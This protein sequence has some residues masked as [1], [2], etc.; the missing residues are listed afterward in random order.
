MWPLWDEEVAVRWGSSGKKD[1]PLV[2]LKSV[3]K[4]HNYFL[5]GPY[6]IPNAL[7]SLCD[8]FVTISRDKVPL[9]GQ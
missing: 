3:V 9:P 1:C 4:K 8:F 7:K 5:S 2:L 6:Y